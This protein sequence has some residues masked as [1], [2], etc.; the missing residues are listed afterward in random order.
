M[1]TRDLPLKRRKSSNS[2]CSAP[3]SWLA[4]EKRAKTSGGVTPGWPV[5]NPALVPSTQWVATKTSRKR[6]KTPALDEPDEKLSDHVPSQ[7]P[8]PTVA[9]W[10][11]S[12]L[13]LQAKTP[14][15]TRLSSI[16]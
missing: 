8:S 14:T 15:A 7:I 11:I 13:K 16:V 6:S 1:K 5:S 12:T 3:H 10:T 9:D 2:T 4:I